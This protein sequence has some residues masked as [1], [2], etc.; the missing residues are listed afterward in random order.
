M[1]FGRKRNIALSGSHIRRQRIADLG[2]LGRY[3]VASFEVMN[4]YAVRRGDESALH[5]C[6]LFVFYLRSACLLSN[7]KREE[8][9]A[10]SR[11]QRS[12]G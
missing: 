5:L 9:K 12:S 8:H 11:K 3:G 1:T 10:Q 2:A 4:F 7:R 6:R